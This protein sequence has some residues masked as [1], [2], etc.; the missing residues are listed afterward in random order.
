M[1]KARHGSLTAGGG[2]NPSAHSRAVHVGSCGI[3]EGSNIK[4]AS[5]AGGQ[6]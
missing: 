6:R 5:S 1:G 4:S 2:Y 3:A